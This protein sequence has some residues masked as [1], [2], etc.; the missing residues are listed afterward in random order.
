MKNKEAKSVIN[1]QNARQSPKNDRHRYPQS[2]AER[3]PTVAPPRP[4]TNAIHP[5]SP[6]K[7]SKVLQKRL[8]PAA[9]R[10][11]LTPP[12]RA[13][14]THSFAPTGSVK[15][16]KTV[17]NAHSDRY[18][19]ARPTA[20]ATAVGDQPAAA[21]LIQKVK[22]NI[23][24][25]RNTDT[26]SVSVPGKIQTTNVDCPTTST[27]QSASKVFPQRRNLQINLA[28]IE[29]LSTSTEPAVPDRIMTTTPTE[30]NKN[31]EITASLASHQTKVHPHL[32]RRKKRQR[33]T[34]H[35]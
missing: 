26:T 9:L 12:P 23:S 28:D 27:H 35:E 2:Y 21:M 14:S 1:R 6:A 5:T 22:V 11:S 25:N 16:D 32:F 15:I 30:K 13:T 29:T 8:R 31:K 24:T 17:I 10:S 18:C 20:A 34:Q 7:T 3:T 4:F 19:T 33:R